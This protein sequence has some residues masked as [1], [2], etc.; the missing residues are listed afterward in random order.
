MLTYTYL[1]LK[2]MTLS[3]LKFQNMW[4]CYFSINLIFHVYLNLF[5]AYHFYQKRYFQCHPIL[6]NSIAVFANSFLP[7]LKGFEIDLEYIIDSFIVSRLLADLLY[8]LWY[9]FC[10]FKLMDEILELTRWMFTSTRSSRYQ[11]LSPWCR[12]YMKT[13]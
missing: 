1:I 7:K 3:Y 13:V 6:K 12:I 2:T 9:L 4:F 5:A 8:V 11:F 10:S